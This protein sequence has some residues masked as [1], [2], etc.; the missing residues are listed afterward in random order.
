MKLLTILNI[1]NWITEFERISYERI[2]CISW[3]LLPFYLFLYRNFIHSQH[4]QDN[5]FSRCC[6]L[7]WFSVYFSSDGPVKKCWDIYLA[8]NLSAYVRQTD[9][10]KCGANS[11]L[12]V[13]GMLTFYRL[14]KHP[15]ISLRINHTDFSNSYTSWN[16]FPNLGASTRMIKWP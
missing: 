6:F 8:S 16:K 1:L 7:K 3:Y 11:N 4:E 14:E 5:I 10:S 12:S 15:E 9:S 13:E 2:S